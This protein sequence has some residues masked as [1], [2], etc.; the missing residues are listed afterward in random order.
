[1]VIINR[2]VESTRKVVVIDDEDDDDSKHLPKTKVICPKCDNS[3]A[4]WFMR[5]MRAA[6]EPPTL[7]YTCTKCGHK[8]RSYG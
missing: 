1:M 2:K 3:D 4:Y 6:D 7:F 5:Q 8:W